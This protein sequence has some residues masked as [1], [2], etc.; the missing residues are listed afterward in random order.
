MMKVKCLTVGAIASNCYLVWCEETKEAMVIDPGGE[1]KRILSEIAKEGLQVK[2]I[3]NTHGHMDHI[4]ANAVVK[5]GTGAQLAIHAEDVP[6]LSDTEMN[7]SAYMG[8]EY[9]APETDLILHE[10]EELTAGKVTLAV[11]H[12]P[13]HSRGSI[14]LKG[15]GVIFSGDTLFADSV[16]RTDFPGGSYEE[17]VT[18]I[19]NKILTC[20]DHFIVYPGHGPATTVGHE[21]VHNPFF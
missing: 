7:L 16:G 17:L 4:A 5:E 20:G 2:Y 12:T 3:V 13:G 15:D 19:K 8:K 10:G 11:L 21:R 1:G 18:S 14:S 6:L 9:C